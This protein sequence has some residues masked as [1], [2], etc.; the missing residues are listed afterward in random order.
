MALR[1]RKSFLMPFRRFASSVEGSAEDA[2]GN[3]VIFAAIVFVNLAMHP[4]PC[5][6][7]CQFAQAINSGSSR[8]TCY[9]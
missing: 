4:K 7:Q 8:M 2:H 9:S 5:Q 3:R 6:P 1:L